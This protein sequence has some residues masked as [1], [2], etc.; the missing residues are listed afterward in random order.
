MRVRIPILDRTALDNKIQDL[1]RTR[2]EG[3]LFQYERSVGICR[4]IFQEKEEELFF[5]PTTQNEQQMEPDNDGVLNSFPFG[6]LKIYQNPE[7]DEFFLCFFPVRS[8]KAAK[9]STCELVFP[10]EQPYPQGINRADRF[11]FSPNI[12]SFLICKNSR[13]VFDANGVC[14]LQ[15]I[16][17]S[18]LQFRGKSN[19]LFC[20]KTESYLRPIE[21]PF[22][23]ASATENKYVKV[24]CLC[25]NK[26]FCFSIK[27]PVLNRSELNA[28]IQEACRDRLTAMDL[29]SS[30]AEVRNLHRNCV[31]EKDWFP[32][33]SN[34]HLITLSR[35]MGINIPF[36]EM[37]FGDI[38]LSS[39]EGSVYLVCI[40]NLFRLGRNQ[41]HRNCR[42]FP[43]W[44]VGTVNSCSTSCLARK[45]SSFS[46][47]GVRLVEQSSGECQLEG[48]K[49]KFVSTEKEGLWGLCLSR[50]QE[51]TPCGSRGLATDERPSTSG[52]TTSVA[53]SGS[54]QQTSSSTV[55]EVTI[56][57]IRTST[58]KSQPSS[59]L[60][61][62]RSSK[63][64]STSMSSSTLR[65]KKT[66]D[67]SPSVNID[68][69]YCIFG[70]KRK[71]KVNVSPASSNLPDATHEQTETSQSSGSCSQTETSNHSA[72]TTTVSTAVTASMSSFA[73]PQHTVRVPIPLSFQNL[74]TP[75]YM[76]HMS[77]SSAFVRSTPVSQLPFQRGIF[78]LW[79][80][81]RSPVLPGPYQQIPFQWPYQAHVNPLSQPSTTSRESHAAVSVANLQQEP[82]WRPPSSTLVTSTITSESAN[83]DEQSRDSDIDVVGV[84][85]DSD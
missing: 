1:V 85:S 45:I 34:C 42:N 54:S 35:G 79:P 70:K 81:G 18:C 76:P 49:L 51:S 11:F 68:H 2:A 56:P 82:L 37:K 16:E 52:L 84:D 27:L 24:M 19:S 62:I 21:R 61:Q 4:E 59:S 48:A 46:S 15:G 20:K 10:E 31:S 73:S 43:F 60:T 67:H 25:K 38:Y 22:E 29:P 50:L 75:S 53:P 6:E 66:S 5:F 71:V 28:K 12:S 78:P 7:K 55:S 13:V 63:K 23:D 41:E 17:I 8:E 3:S 36:C 65:R 83:N 57:D 14:S 39:Y 9:G 77:T 44:Q 32:R 80:Y 64:S 33:Q 58:S 40:A 30:E 26:G 72:L 47:R 74:Y 69:S